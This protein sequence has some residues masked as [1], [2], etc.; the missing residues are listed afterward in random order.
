[1]LEHKMA[2]QTTGEKAGS[3]LPH[4]AVVWAQRKDKL[5]VTVRLD[6]CGKPDIQL[7]ENSLY[8]KGAGGPEKVVHEATLEFYHDIIPEESKYTI[9][10]REIIF[11][12]R[13]KELEKGFWPRLLK[14]NKKVHFLK[15]DFDKW[16]DEDD[17][18]ADDNE[19][20]NLEQMMNSMGGLGGGAGGLEQEE[21]PDEDSDD[22]DLPDLQ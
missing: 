13:K 18:D 19:D 1:M 3:I 21:E 20:M 9:G 6:N 8:F 7:K 22:E 16:R 10:G 11:M 5:W 12:L 2:S 4:P 17:S 14:D 15:T